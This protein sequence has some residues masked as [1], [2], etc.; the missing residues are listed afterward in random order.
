MCGARIGALVSRNADLMQTA[1][2][3]GQARLSPPTFGQIASEAALDT[4]PSYFEEVKE[5]YVARRDVV[6]EMLNKIPGVFCPNPGGAFYC[7]AQLPVANADHFCQWMLESFSYEGATVMMAPA[8]GFYSN[9]DLGLNQVRIAYVLTRDDLKKA[10][11]A[12]EKGLE[13]Y[14]G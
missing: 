8:S 2:K 1:L 4:P 9:P 11:I 7:V 10:I 5:R 13:A 12:L 14:K 6:V 3:F